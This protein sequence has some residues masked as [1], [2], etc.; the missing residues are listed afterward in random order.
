MLVRLSNLY[1]GLDERMKDSWLNILDEYLSRY[2]K[3]YG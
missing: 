1:Q 2:G 3:E